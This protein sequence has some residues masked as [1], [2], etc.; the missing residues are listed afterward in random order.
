MRKQF[1]GVLPLGKIYYDRGKILSA[2]KTS[3]RA[4]ITGLFSTWDLRQEFRNDGGAPIEAG[5]MFTFPWKTELLGMNMRIGTRDFKGKVI[6]RKDFCGSM[7]EN[8]VD[9]IIRFDEP[10]YEVYGANLGI[11]EANEI[12]LVD[13]HFAYFL[14]YEK[15]YMR[16]YIP[17]W[18]F[19]SCEIFN[20]SIVLNGDIAKGDIQSPGHSVII[21]EADNNGKQLRLNS[22]RPPERDFILLMQGDCAASHILQTTTKVER[23]MAASFEPLSSRRKKW[24]VFLKLLVDCSGSMEGTAIIEVK[25]GLMDIVKLLQPED[26]VTYSRFGSDVEYLWRTPRP[27]DPYHI[28]QLISAIEK[29]DACMGGTNMKDALLSMYS[30]IRRTEVV[31]LAPALVLITDGQAGSPDEVIEAAKKSHNRIFV[32]GIG[33]FI[34][35]ELLH[36]IAEKTNG[37]CEIAYS[38][39]DIAKAIVRIFNQLSRSIASGVEVVW[40]AQPN[41]EADIP[42]YL[43]PGETIHCFAEFGY[44]ANIVPT[45]QCNV[46]LRYRIGNKR[47][48]SRASHLETLESNDLARF[49]YARM[50][51]ECSYRA[52]RKDLSLQFQL[53][54]DQTA[55]ILTEG[56]GDRFPESEDDFNMIYNARGWNSA[57]FLDGEEN[58]RRNVISHASWIERQKVARKRLSAK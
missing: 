48:D 53:L 37:I 2:K 46:K 6:E 40:P 49:A 27:C 29:T 13:F 12:I 58:K 55:L 15:R 25:R 23:V 14:D 9:S 38:A 7:D 57:I 41:W 44:S 10:A 30:Y 56:K 20:M 50:S 3:L 8:L 16:L 21:E 31:D 11:I 26:H 47:H 36:G 43:Y 54:N 35:E 5:Y 19:G 24:P 42:H 33:N 1:H 18:N 51:G 17:A 22:S 32:I 4:N 28:Q 45:P 34:D 52:I 39:K